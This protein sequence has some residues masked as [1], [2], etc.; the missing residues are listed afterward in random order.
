VTG[1]SPVPW[2]QE[3]LEGVIFERPIDI[4]SG[5]SRL[6]ARLARDATSAFRSDPG[7]SRRTDLERDMGT[8]RDP[9]VSRVRAAYFEQPFRDRSFDLVT[10]ALWI[11]R[12]G[13]A[14]RAVVE[15][16][17]I[18]SRY[19]L[20]VVRH[21]ETPH[22]RYS[23]PSSR[24]SSAMAGDVLQAFDEERLSGLVT[25]AGLR[26]VRL[27]SSGRDT[28]LLRQAVALLAGKRG[29]A[30]GFLGVLAERP[31]ND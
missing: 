8:L 15:L 6:A 1:P 14:P 29:D 24:T 13:A 22:V 5:D 17:R 16:K 3:L 2:V 10:A 20:I 4:G 31:D 27:R 25:G 26:V 11:D 18:S 19:V 23:P 7:S 9:E 12:I 30:P 21:R 28:G